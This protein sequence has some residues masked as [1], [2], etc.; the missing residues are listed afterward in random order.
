G[1]PTEKEIFDGVVRAF[2]ERVSVSPVTKTQ[3]VAIRVEMKDAELAAR[4]ANALANAYIQSQLEAK[5]NVTSTATGWMSDQL[6]G[7][8]QQLQ[9]SERALQEFRERENLVD[10]NG[11]VTTVTAGELSETGDRLVDARRQ[12]AEA[13]S[14]YRQIEALKGGDWRK[15]VSVPVVLSNP[16]VQQFRTQEAKARSRVQELSLRYGPK[17]P[18]MIAAQEELESAV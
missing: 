17:H 14:Q 5:L 18:T 12:R 8:R 4:A 11:Q 10:V 7:L 16:L 1:P 2:M 6:S 3:L 15:L 9:D 13:E